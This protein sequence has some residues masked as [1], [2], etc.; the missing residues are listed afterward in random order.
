ME[1]KHKMPPEGAPR[2]ANIAYDAD[3]TAA[4]DKNAEY[5]TPNL[6]QFA[7]K[8]LIILDVAELIRVLVVTFEVPIGR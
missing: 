7:K 8:C 4:R 5:M 6:L 1:R 3:E 2:N